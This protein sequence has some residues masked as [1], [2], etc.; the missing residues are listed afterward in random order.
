MGHS[1]GGNLP[2]NASQGLT[3]TIILNGELAKAFIFVPLN[4]AEAG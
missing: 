4:L 3:Q 2:G 1:G